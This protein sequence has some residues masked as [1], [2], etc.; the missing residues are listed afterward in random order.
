MH[1]APRNR[2]SRLDGLLDQ[3]ALQKWAIVNTQ[4]ELAL[5]ELQRLGVGVEL[6]GSVAR[7]EFRVHSDVDF[8][9][10]GRG[11]LSEADV[12]KGIAD[13]LRDAS[14]DLVFVDRI[15]PH[16]L[17]LMRLDAQAR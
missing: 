9:V 1:L 13:H 3:R 16:K 17:E 2:S 14:F 4:V 7:G 8:L 12:Y 10:T 5:A 6:F 15:A 11:P